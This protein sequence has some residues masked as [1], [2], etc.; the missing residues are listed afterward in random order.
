MRTGL[1]L[2]A[3]VLGGASAWAR[4][5]ASANRI[6][7][8]QGIS[9]PATTSPVNYSNGFVTTNPSVASKLSGPQLSLEYDTGEDSSNN[10]RSGM[11]VELGYGNGQ[12]GA[13]AG[14]YDRD[15]TN[16]E[17]RWGGMIGVGSGSFSFG[18]G[19]REENSYSLG[20][21]M[22]GS[23]GHRFGATADLVKV[24][25]G[26]D[27]SSVG[28]GYSYLGNSWIFAVDASKREQ[29]RATT[30]DVILVTPGLLIQAN[31]LSVSVSYDLYTND[32]NDAFEDQIWF[33]IGFG[34]DRF[35]LS[36]YH[37]YVNDWSLV[38]SLS[39]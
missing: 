12:V 9:S 24:D 36:V 38:G 3:M 8:S 7:V 34:S 28:V 21:L 33:G 32:E 10:D 18:V 22:G 31:S 37:D 27:V 6:A 20:L 13:I 39:F 19:Y 4:P 1:F 16:C 5:S 15:C 17:G 11:G 30:N 14:Y 2:A 25:S 29:K 26:N 35:H 23:G